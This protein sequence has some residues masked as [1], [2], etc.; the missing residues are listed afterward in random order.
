MNMFNQGI[1]FIVAL[2]LFT[3]L[4]VA[5]PVFQ[6]VVEAVESECDP[7]VETCEGDEVE[8]GLVDEVDPGD[9]TQK[10]DPSLQGDPSDAGGL[11]TCSGIDCGTCEFV[12]LL[13]NI[14]DFL[15]TIMASIAALLIMW[16]GFLLVS[17]GGDT[18]QIS[19]AKGIFTNVVV[20]LA[21]MLAAWLI[22]DTIMKTFLVYNDRPGET[23]F[24]PWNE[25]ACST[26]TKLEDSVKALPGSTNVLIREYELPGDE[27]DQRWNYVIMEPQIGGATACV[28]RITGGAEDEATCI[29]DKNMILSANPQRF[30][31]QNCD[32]SS[33]PPPSGYRSSLPECGAYAHPAGQL[34]YPGD[35]SREV[36]FPAVDDVAGNQPGYNY[37]CSSIIPPKWI[38]LQNLSGG[39]SA[40]TRISPN[41]SI[42]DLNVSGTCGGGGRFWYIDRRA[43]EGLEAINQSLGKRLSVN[44]AHRSPGC[45]AIIK[46][47]SSNPANVA[48]CSQHSA[49]SGFDLAVPSGVSRCD[50]V[51][52]CRS[53]G[54]SFIMTYTTA[55]H[56]HC[57]WRR[58][59]GGE[60]GPHTS[61]C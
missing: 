28:R 1:K 49:G 32:G 29:S 16:A 36:C 34:C 19:K 21:I 5:A 22:V 20:G 54:A 41:Y 26:Q 14:I 58:G 9:T 7:A 43:V 50:V 15:I 23:Q 12:A 17:A 57:D 8:D 42:S 2:V 4:I 6:G 46:S 59:G 61:S 13:N 39:L 48:R 27:G 24:G 33:Q 37:L 56:V 53:A 55:S 18:G 38:D 60:K 47:R 40:S 25:I 35:G 30:A 31:I 44:S 51:R 45:Q 11:V 3:I 10:S 52:A